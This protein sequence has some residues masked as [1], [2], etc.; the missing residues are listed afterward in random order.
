MIQWITAFVSG[1]SCRAKHHKTQIHEKH[2]QA[3][4]THFSI[5]AL[6]LS[7]SRT[8]DVL[9]NV[10]QTCS[11]KFY[12]SV[13]LPMKCI[14][15]IPHTKNETG[16]IWTLWHRTTQQIVSRWKGCRQA[17]LS[18]FNSEKCV[19]YVKPNNSWHSG[20]Y[21]EKK[22]NDHQPKLG[23]CWCVFL[24]V[25]WCF[26]PQPS[27]C[28]AADGCWL[29]P[30]SHW[31]IQCDPDLGSYGSDP[32]PAHCCGPQTSPWSPQAEQQTEKKNQSHVL[33]P[34]R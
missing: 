34:E 22:A 14:K 1:A 24:H 17:A 8:P 9:L 23:F 29:H 2:I 10:G 11:V 3:S 5:T 32:H 27:S 6:L 33:V 16:F 13:L 30:P 12:R 21:Y 28:S 31:C 18:S 20:C 19:S 15:K 25:P 7:H 26:H 4:G